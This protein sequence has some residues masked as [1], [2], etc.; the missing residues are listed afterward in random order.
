MVAHPT[1]RPHVRGIQER[2][3]RRPGD[4]VVD[5]L[6]DPPTARETELTQSPRPS[7]HL[8]AEACPL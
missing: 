2:T 3:T 7:K 1:R 4:D 8:L 5:L 6:R